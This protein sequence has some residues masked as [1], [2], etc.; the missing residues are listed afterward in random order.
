M[1]CDFNNLQ[2]AHVSS[3]FAFSTFREN[4]FFGKMFLFPFCSD[5]ERFA[6]NLH[7]FS[8]LFQLGLGG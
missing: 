8:L 4:F 7:N 6:S 2:R 1:R 3:V 5:T